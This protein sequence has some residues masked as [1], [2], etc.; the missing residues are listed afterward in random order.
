LIEKTKRLRIFAGPNGSGKSTLIEAFKNNNDSRIKLGIVVNADEIEK[1]FIENGFIDF[2]DYHLNISKNSF[3]G[4]VSTSGLI[5]EKYTKFE[6]LNSFFVDENK[7]RTNFKLDSYIAADVSEFI[8][9]SLLNEGVSFSFET[10]F[11]HPSKLEIIKKSRIF[12]F[13]CPLRSTS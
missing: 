3:I 5:G 7:L 9:Q 1:N 2:S 12:N 10:V 8:R 4:F 13:F 6:I 11:S